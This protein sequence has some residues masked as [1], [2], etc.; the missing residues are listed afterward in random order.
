MEGVRREHICA[1]GPPTRLPARNLS[2]S[3]WCSPCHSGPQRLSTVN[4]GQRGWR[5]N[6]WLTTLHQRH[7]RSQPPLP[8][9]RTPLQFAGSLPADFPRPSLLKSAPICDTDPGD[10]IGDDNLL[11]G[12]YES[13]W[14]VDLTCAEAQ[15]LLQLQGRT[16]G[17]IFGARQGRQLWRSRYVR[18]STSN[19]QKTRGRLQQRRSGSSRSLILKQSAP[20]QTSRVP[21]PSMT[22]PE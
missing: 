13:V 6:R 4:I 1:T 17:T 15:L 16:I 12:Q 22:Q 2:G 18:A 8:P 5:Q 7:N 10:N 14:P 21:K 11:R 20:R 19:S 9:L 3:G